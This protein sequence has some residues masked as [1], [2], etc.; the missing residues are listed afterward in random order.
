MNKPIVPTGTGKRTLRIVGMAGEL[1]EVIDNI[2]LSSSTQTGHFSGLCLY[3]RQPGGHCHE[4]HSALV[5][6]FSSVSPSLS[7]QI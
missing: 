2:L 1:A 4:T 7:R 5:E 3:C 6:A